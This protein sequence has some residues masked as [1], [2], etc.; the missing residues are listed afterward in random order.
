MMKS[1]L[2]SIIVPVYKVEKYIDECIKSIINQTYTNLEIILIDDGSPDNCGKICDGYAKNDKR[3]KVIHQKNMGQSVARNVGLEYAKGD[4]IGFVDSD[5][6]IK[7]NMFEVLHNNLVSYS[8][9]IS[10]CNIIKVKNNKLEKMENYNDITLIKSDKILEELIDGNITNYIYNKLYKK[11]LWKDIR[12]P[13]GKILE[14]M[15]IMYKILEKTEHIVCTNNTEYYYRIRS[16]SSIANI[17][18]DV[19]FLLKEVTENRYN[20]LICKNYKLKE[21]LNKCKMLDIVQYFYNLSFCKEKELYFG[22]EFANDYKFYR[23]N[24][25]KYKD[26][27][28]R[29]QSKRKKLEM[30]LLYKSKRLYY[31]YSIVR[32]S[33]KR[34]IKK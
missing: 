2:I 20:Y 34:K 33:I 31:S 21:V 16:D 4:F 22:K 27:I 3:I 1:D 11:E 5:D 19:T 13:K 30:W 7:N 8:A 9:D 12:F 28:Y 24:F 6:Y 15:D 26:R 25:K 18:K 17:D 29:G 14:D 23:D 32:N 10:I